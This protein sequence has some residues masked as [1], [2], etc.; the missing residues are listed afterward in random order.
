MAAGILVCDD[1]K[2]I[3]ESLEL[4]IHS[5]NR[6]RFLGAFES[7]D[8]IVPLI[9]VLKPDIVLMDIDMPGINGL[10]AVAMVR[11]HR[12]DLPVIMLTVFDDEERVFTALRNGAIGYLLKS[13]PP[14]RLLE[15]LAEVSEGGA[16][17]SPSIARKVMSYFNAQQKSPAPD[18]HLTAREKEVLAA[19][20]S[21]LSYKMTA[22]KLFI[23][24][25]TVRTHV[26]NIY[27]KLHVQTVAEAVSK[28][29][30]EG[31]V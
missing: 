9:Q 25:E 16:P 6:F 2:L 22:E 11:A 4:L 3:R 31:L 29:V 26:K 8:E 12:P 24:Y 20:V 10:D 7:A 17:M 14:E 30:R 18:Y 23:G 1:S 19:L 5:D 21:G 15:A 13:T 27:E 28:S